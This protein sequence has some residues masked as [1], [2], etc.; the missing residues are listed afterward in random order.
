MSGNMGI[1]LML[2]WKTSEMVDDPDAAIRAVIG[3]DI[4][5][6]LSFGEYGHCVGGCPN[7]DR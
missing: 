4:P 1:G 3:E 7:G 6:E 2:K 5:Y